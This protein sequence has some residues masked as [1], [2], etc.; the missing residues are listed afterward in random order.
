[1][2]ESCCPLPGM[3]LTLSFSFPGTWVSRAMAQEWCLAGRGWKA[4]Y[5]MKGSEG[6]SEGRVVW[7]LSGGEA[8][9]TPSREARR[10]R[11]STSHAHRQ[12]C[13]APAHFSPFPCTQ[14]PFSASIKQPRET[15]KKGA[16]RAKTSGDFGGEQSWSVASLNVPTCHILMKGDPEAPREDA[17]VRGSTPK[18]TP[19]EM[20]PV[21]AELPSKR[22]S[23][24]LC[25]VQEFG[26]AVEQASGSP[27]YGRNTSKYSR[28]C[29]GRRIGG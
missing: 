11:S 10:G 4:V 24:S 12:R 29:R 14:F 8:G 21:F 17:D 26:S 19:G 1:V 13:R 9:L 20:K 5:G 6:G 16:A 23:A 22:H 25:E 27:S 2:G 15:A 28:T 3:P 7:R 18:Q